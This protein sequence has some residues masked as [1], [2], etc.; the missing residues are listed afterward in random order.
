MALATWA[1]GVPAAMRWQSSNRPVGMSGALRWAT[2]IA[3]VVSWLGHLRT[4]LGGL[5]LWWTLTAPPPSP[6]STSRG[7][8]PISW[9]RQ[10]TERVRSRNRVRP[11]GP[12]P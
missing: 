2:K 10:R 7:Q 6:V 8:V 5:P 9:L 12:P 11:P 1:T 3:G 4:Y